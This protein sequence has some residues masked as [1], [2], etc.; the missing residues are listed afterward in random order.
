M[1]NTAKMA[2]YYN[3]QN[4]VVKKIVSEL[5]REIPLFMV[6]EFLKLEFLEVLSL[7]HC[8]D[9]NWAIKKNYVVLERG[10]LEYHA[11]QYS[12]IPGSS[13]IF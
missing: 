9:G 6:L 2:K 12:S 8:S 11:T 7:W 13:T 10:K 3:F 1:T 5:Y 4:F